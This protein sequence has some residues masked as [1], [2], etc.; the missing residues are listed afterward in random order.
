MNEQIYHYAQIK[1]YISYLIRMITTIYRCNNIAHL[2]TFPDMLFYSIIERFMRCLYRIHGGI[3]DLCYNLKAKEVTHMKKI[4]AL[5][6]SAILLVTT[7]L[8]I[9]MAEG[10]ENDAMHG[11]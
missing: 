10:T 6:M 3:K 9:V 2:C 7:C 8:T 4:T 1:L 5:I 11:A